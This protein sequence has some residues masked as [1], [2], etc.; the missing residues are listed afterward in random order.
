MWKAIGLL[1]VLSW[2]EL[3]LE[4]CGT[5][6]PYHRALEPL[7]KDSNAFGDENQNEQDPDTKSLYR[8]RAG[9]CLQ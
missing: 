5:F 6:M 2:I 1:F 9:R 8:S 4:F 3:T 7:Q